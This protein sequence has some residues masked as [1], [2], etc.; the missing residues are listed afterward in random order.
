MRHGTGSDDGFSGRKRACGR[1]RTGL[2]QTSLG[3]TKRRLLVGDFR[4]Y[5]EIPRYVKSCAPRFQCCHLAPEFSVE[6][7]SLWD[8]FSSFSGGKLDRQLTTLSET[9]SSALESNDTGPVPI[10]LVEGFFVENF[11]AFLHLCHFNAYPCTQLQSKSL[12]PL[13]RA[14]SHISHHS[15]PRAAHSK[16]CASYWYETFLNPSSSLSYLRT[17]L[18]LV[19]S[20]WGDCLARNVDCSEQILQGCT[21]SERDRMLDYT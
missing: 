4:I 5:R 3:S 7:K 2:F 19:K 6:R 12:P 16:P 15:S 21:S 20:S 1:Q 8:H 13:C 11:E 17:K 10:F 14:Q 9:C 18:A